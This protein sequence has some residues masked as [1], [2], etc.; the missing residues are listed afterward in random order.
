VD[1]TGSPWLGAGPIPMGKPIVQ[2]SRWW[3]FAGPLA[4]FFGDA[5]NRLYA[6]N[7]MNHAIYGYVLNTVLLSEFYFAPVLVEK[8]LDTHSPVALRL[9]LG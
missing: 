5:R 3:F 2:V 9:R 7:V 4:A 1:K 8:P 6:R